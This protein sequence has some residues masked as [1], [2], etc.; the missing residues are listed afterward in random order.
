VTLNIISIQAGYRSLGAGVKDHPYYHRLRAQLDAAT[1]NAACVTNYE[2]EVTTSN[3]PPG[4]ATVGL[5]I[6]NEW[7]CTGV[8]I[9]DVP[10][11]NTPYVAYRGKRGESTMLPPVASLTICQSQMS[12]P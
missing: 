6:G 12:S 2:C 8:L 4:A 10:R 11:D 9:N 3:T 5:I 7:N 1:G